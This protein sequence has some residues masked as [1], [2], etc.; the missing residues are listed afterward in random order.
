M[1]QVPV[2]R[3]GACCLSSTVRTVPVKTPLLHVH[4]CLQKRRFSVV[5]E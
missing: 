3:G 2:A 5:E 4:D 1:V